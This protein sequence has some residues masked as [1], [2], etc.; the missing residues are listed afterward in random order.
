MIKRAPRQPRHRTRLPAGFQPSVPALSWTAAIDGGDAVI[1]TLTPVVISA[2]PV[3]ITNEG[4]APISFTITTPTEFVLHYAAPVTSTDTIVVP[5]NVDQ[6][7]S[8]IG[9][10]LAPGQFTFP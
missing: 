8:A 10:T 5:G 6:V 9:G 2:L 4:I 1:T 7:K 3:G